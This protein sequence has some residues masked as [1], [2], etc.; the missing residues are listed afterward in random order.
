MN[1]TDR[2]Y[3]ITSALHTG[4]RL[5]RTTPW[6]AERFEVSTRTIKRDMAALLEIGVPIVSQDG[7]GGG[8]RLM[9]HTALPPVTFTAGEASAV[10]IALAAEPQIPFAAD[11]AAGLQKVLGAMNHVQREE[12]TQM[13]RRVWMRRSPAQKRG[14]SAKILDEA[15]RMQVVV[16]I[17]YVD[18]RGRVTRRRPVEPM[19]FVRTQEHWSLLAWCQRRKAGR[20][21]RLDRVSKAWLTRTPCV[22][23]DLTEVFGEPPEYAQPV[24]LQS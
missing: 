18:E 15:L 11:G 9:Q 24:L 14:E 7:R 3:A 13:A 22:Q 17:N 1:R 23:H 10:A 16:F 19:A 6:L 4:G 21:F 8:Y 12:A 20:W 5:G 2:L